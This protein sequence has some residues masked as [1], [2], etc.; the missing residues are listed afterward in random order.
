MLTCYIICLVFVSWN[1]CIEIVCLNIVYGSYSTLI[2]L[3][4]NCNKDTLCT[5]HLSVCSFSIKALE[6]CFLCKWPYFIGILIRQFWR[7][8]GTY[9]YFFFI[10]TSKTA[11]ESSS[12]ETL[13]FDTKLSAR[14]SCLL[15]C[16]VDYV[17][18]LLLYTYHFTGV[19][20]L[21]VLCDNISM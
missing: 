11:R 1:H 18:K 6:D 8:Y 16:V 14:F 12:V 17:V 13:L 15:S 4:K 21:L 19:I 3:I 5:Q 2:I 20:G 7:S 10:D 9:K